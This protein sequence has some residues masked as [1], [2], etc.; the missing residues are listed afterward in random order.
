ME[1]LFKIVE[2]ALAAAS[3]EQKPQTFLLLFGLI[4]VRFVSFVL[5]APYFGGAAVSGRVKTA[6]AAALV[7][8]VYPTLLGD[9]NNRFA[10]E[11]NVIIFIALILKEAVVGFVL[12]FAS[13]L[14]FQS[15]QIAGRIIDV[16]RGAS[17]SEVHS[18][19]L[20]AQ[21]SELGQVK[22]QL[23]I[24]LFVTTGAHLIFL[25]T[26]MISYELIPVTKFPN[27]EFGWGAEAQYIVFLTGNMVA[28]GMQLAVPA[29]ITLLTT[30][31][32]FGI[33]NRVA[34]QINVFFLSMPV[35]MFLGIFVVFLSATYWI[36]IFQRLFDNSYEQFVHLLEEIAR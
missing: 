21:V 35:K 19:Q 24:F 8:L 33:V 34:P 26:L 28:V 15:V 1:Q 29:I 14:T 10:S 12:G 4:F 7:I 32:A 6:I 27:I 36:H 18:P 20:Q 13:S 31:L 3:I 5:I 30:E 9:A 16:Q 23:A 17:M 2:T 25:R 11:I 22:L